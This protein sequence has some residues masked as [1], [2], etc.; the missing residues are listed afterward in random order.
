M[1]TT[2]T[3]YPSAIARACAAIDEARVFRDLP[4]GYIRIVVRII[5]KIRLSCLKS[6]IYAS[7]GTIAKESGKS[8]ETVGRAVKWLE[9]NG[10][11][12]RTQ[13]ARNGLRGS[14]SPITPTD[15]LIEALTLRGKSSAQPLKMTHTSGHSGLTLDVQETGASKGSPVTADASLSTLPRTQSKERQP[16]KPAAYVRKDGVFIPSDVAWLVDQKGLRATAVLKLMKLAKDNQQR[17]SD[18]V[19]ATRQYLDVLADNGLFAYLR[20]LVTQD[21]DYRYVVQQESR[22]LQA[23]QL[24]QRLEQKSVELEGRSFATRDG[25]IRVFVQAK[26]ML[27][28]LDARRGTGYRPMDAAF[29]DALDEGR[30]IGVST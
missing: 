21:R 23:A 25:Q 3:A 4:D 9:D 16:D 6:P 8:V 2:A 22:G 30:L 19:Q 29:L 17:L 18:V 27:K 1:T 20:K 10:L 13:K 12:E 26:G 11:I 14:T 7:R 28:V 15:A 5:K 24:K